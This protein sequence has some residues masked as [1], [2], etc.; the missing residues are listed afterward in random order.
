LFDEVDIVSGI[1]IV[2]VKIDSS[3]NDRYDQQNNSFCAKWRAMTMAKYFAFH[4]LKKPGEEVLNVLNKVAPDIALA[5]FS[6]ETSC[7]CI[8]TWSPLEHGREDYLFSLWEA[9]NLQDVEATV[10]SFGLLEYF[11]LD[12]MRVD[13]I[14]WRTL[15]GSEI[16]RT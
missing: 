14:D 6:D 12:T 7:T 5:M 3:I 16:K 2:F 11:T 8:K 1:K 4:R 9:D 15:A 10:E 13:E